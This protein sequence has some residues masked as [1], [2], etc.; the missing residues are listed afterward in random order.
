MDQ[1]PQDCCAS[2][3]PLPPFERPIR[4]PEGVE[5]GVADPPVARVGQSGRWRLS[6]TVSEDVPEGTEVQVLFDGGRHVKGSF[7]PLQVTEPDAPGFVSIARADGT[8]IPPTGMPQPGLVAFAA[9]AGGLRR[10]EGLNV[11]LGGP[12]GT[13]PPRL[14]LLPKM[15]L[16]LVPEPA[17]PDVPAINAEPGRRV[18]GACLVHITGGT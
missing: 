11:D 13:V 2:P 8:A 17:D 16:L 7:R 9:P 3:V 1:T 5:C 15:V 10:G 18:I 6:F 12:A 4:V 14:D